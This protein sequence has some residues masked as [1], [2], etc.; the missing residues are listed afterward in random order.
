MCGTH[1]DKLNQILTFFLGASCIAV[2]MPLTRKYTKARKG[3]RS[4]PGNQWTRK[5]TEPV[6]TEPV[7][8]EPVADQDVNVEEEPQI[9]TNRKLTQYAFDNEN[10]DDSDLSEEHSDADC[11]IDECRRLVDFS[12]INGLLTFAAVCIACGKSSLALREDKWQGCMARAPSISTF[13]RT[14][15]RH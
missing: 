8:L 13:R 7:P 1:L 11:E 9:S 3:R 12:R 5:A 14:N 10:S 4:F 6:E 15:T 2:T